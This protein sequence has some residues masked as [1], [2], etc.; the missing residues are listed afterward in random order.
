MVS[1]V[2]PV[3]DGARF[4]SAAVASVQR[5]AG[6]GLE[7]LVHDD[8]STDGTPKLLTQLAAADARIDASRSPRCGPAESRNRLI[9]RA[10]GEYVGFLD[11]DDL[12]P[13]GRLARQLARLEGRPGTVPGVL[14]ESVLFHTL[15]PAGRP[16]PSAG[17]RRVLAGLLGAGLFRREAIGAAGR[18]AP[19]L[20]VAD[21]F[22]FL[23]RLIE[24]RGPLEIERDVALWYRQHPGQHTADLEFT[25]RGTARALARSLQRRRRATGS[26]EGLTWRS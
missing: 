10:R 14:G 15:D 25:G 7:L 19:E 16:A 24:A 18:F 6:V 13:D 20:R 22:D 26:A 1:V 17:N 21:D 9:A 12:W 23:L 4:L 11:H 2:M 5:Q 8:G 3:H